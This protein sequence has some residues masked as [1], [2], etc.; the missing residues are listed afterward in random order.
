MVSDPQYCRL[1]DIISVSAIP[2]WFS[3][4]LV[5]ASSMCSSTMNMDRTPT[6]KAGNCGFSET[7]VF[8]FSKNCGFLLFLKLCFLLLLKLR[9]FLQNWGFLLFALLLKLCRVFCVFCLFYH[10]GLLLLLKL[11]FVASLK[12]LVCC[13]SLNCGF[14]LLNFGVS[15]PS[16]NCGMLLLLKLG[17][18]A[19]Y[20]MG[21][22]WFA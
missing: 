13:S 17:I 15:C 1:L 9:T 2:R 12:I 10:R 5:W 8:W 3:A 14:L 4:G 19:A 22:S 7:E 11:Y 16:Y 18:A 6:G 20:K 21:V